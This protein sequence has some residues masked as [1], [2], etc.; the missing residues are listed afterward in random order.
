MRDSLSF[1][2]LTSWS[3]ILLVV[4]IPACSSPES[5]PSVAPSPATTVQPVPATPQTPPPTPVSV[6]TLLQ[7]AEDKAVSAAS[8]TQTAQSPDDWMIAEQ[9]LKRAIALLK[10]VPA[11]SPKRALAQQRLAEYQR[12]LNLTQRRV[13]ITPGQSP[14]TAPNAPDGI[15]LIVGGSPSNLK[16]E[17]AKAAQAEAVNTIG[18]INR[19]QQAFRLEQERFASSF[20][21]L[22]LD[23]KPETQNYTYQIESASAEQVITTAIAKISGINSYTGVVFIGKTSEGDPVTLPGICGTAQPATVAPE[24]P[25][26]NGNNIECPANSVKL[27]P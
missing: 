17:D 12:N 26:V 5:P 11:S 4:A 8:V 22:K 1:K 10:S 23:L 16:P 2:S 24:P 27:R 18:R 21:E 14:A 3:A 25:S 19:A 13:K 7:E 20:E 15:P 6:D 9:Q